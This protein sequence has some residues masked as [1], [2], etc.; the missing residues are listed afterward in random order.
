MDTT[1]AGTPHVACYIDIIVTGTDDANHLRN[2]EAVLDSLQ[3]HGIKAKE[4]KCTLWVSQYS[5]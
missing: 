4:S 5:T 1:L 2:L 3:K